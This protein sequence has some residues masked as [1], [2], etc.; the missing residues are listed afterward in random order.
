MP[1]LTIII[2]TAGRRSGLPDLVRSLQGQRLFRDRAEIVLVDDAL[3]PGSYLDLDVRVV[4]TPG[5]RGPAYARNRGVDASGGG[6]LLFLDDDV[7]VA[8]DYAPKVLDLVELDVAAAGGPAYPAQEPSTAIER[9]LDAMG[10]LQQPVRNSEGDILC[11]PSVQLL[12]K[13]TLFE[14]SGGFDEQFPYPGGEDND[15]FL[16]LRHLGASIAFERD[17]SVRHDNRM[18]LVTFA[19][20]FFRYG[21][22]TR[23]ACVKH[24][25]APNYAG[26]RMSARTE[27]FRDTPGL[28]RAIVHDPWSRAP[29]GRPVDS[30]L[31]A[32]LSCVR[33]LAYEMGGLAALSRVKSRDAR[34][35]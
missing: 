33:L 18:G 23:L 21:V 31:F 35:A 14:Q 30:A 13:K 20:R 22:G 19:R 2:P 3:S 7:S 10:F 28:L 6:H 29:S 26:F 8:Q 17:L 25:L 16:R 5:G 11:V 4:R 32:G 15:L 1:I 9:Y 12:V 24:G 27:I 34:A